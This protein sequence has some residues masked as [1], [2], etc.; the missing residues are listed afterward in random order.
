[1]TFPVSHLI[2]N[3]AV[4]DDKYKIKGLKKIYYKSVLSLNF[5]VLS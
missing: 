2:R 3:L 1:M 4:C 5:K